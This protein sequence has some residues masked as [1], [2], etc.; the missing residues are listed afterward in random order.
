[1]NKRENFAVKLM[2]YLNSLTRWDFEIKEL[3]GL[4]AL[5]TTLTNEKGLEM[6]IYYEIGK[7]G[8]LLRI[9]CNYN[10]YTVEYLKDKLCKKD[11]NFPLYVEETDEVVFALRTLMPLEFTVQEIHTIVN[12]RMLVMIEIVNEAINATINGI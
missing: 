4:Y 10:K 3:T 1:M 5:Q 9:I 7:D 12:Q 2:D 11:Y 8:A 6:L